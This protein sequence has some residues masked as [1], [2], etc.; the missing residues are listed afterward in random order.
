[1]PA[2]RLQGIQ[3]FE[4]QAGY[5]QRETGKFIPDGNEIFTTLMKRF[6][7]HRNPQAIPAQVALVS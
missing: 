2:A 5:I 4:L 1:M 6:Q 7:A 3:V